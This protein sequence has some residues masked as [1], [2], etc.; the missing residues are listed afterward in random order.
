MVIAMLRNVRTVVGL[1][2]VGGA[3]A[4]VV[5]GWVTGFFG[6]AVDFVSQ[7]WNGFMV[8]LNQPLGLEHLAAGLGSLVVAAV[9]I[10]V[11]FAIIEN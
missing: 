11:I 8:W 9:A 5:I 2:L 3:V 1:S 6:R 4:A 7:L 10:M